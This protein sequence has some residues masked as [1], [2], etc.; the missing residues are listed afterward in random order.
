[1]LRALSLLAYY[2]LTASC[3][4]VGVDVLFTPPGMVLLLRTRP[5][6]P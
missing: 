2:A 6:S 1:M 4:D 5:R 3:Q